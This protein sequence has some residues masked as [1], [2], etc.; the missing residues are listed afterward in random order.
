MLGFLY[1]VYYE[2]ISL[3]TAEQAEL[4]KKCLIK[5][6]GTVKNEQI[7]A[8]TLKSILIVNNTSKFNNEDLKKN[9]NVVR[10]LERNSKSDD[11]IGIAKKAKETFGLVY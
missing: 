4:I 5:F 3:F 8:Q 11:I 6:L 7:L 9:T 2:S 1:I 10:D